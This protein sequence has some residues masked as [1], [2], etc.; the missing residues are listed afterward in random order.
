MTKEKVYKH[1]CANCGY[2]TDR[3]WSYQYHINRK[4]PCKRKE[5]E[6]T[7]KAKDAD[8]VTSAP[9]VVS[10]HICNKCG[11]QFVNRQNKYRHMKNNSCKLPETVRVEEESDMQKQ[12]NKLQKEVDDLK[13]AVSFITSTFDN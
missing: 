2:G 12:I 11:M 10:K 7:G 9:N 3:I 13:R 4:K 5:P 6:S 1:V 8:V